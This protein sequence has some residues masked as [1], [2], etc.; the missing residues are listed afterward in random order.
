MVKASVEYGA[1][2]FD[3]AIRFFRGKLNVPTARYDDLVKE[4]HAKGFMVAGAMKAELLTDLKTAVDRVIAGGGTLETFRKDFDKIVSDNGWRY[5]GG[6]NW[7]TRVIY[8]TNLRQSYNTGRWAQVSDP[9]VVKLRPYLMYRHSG[10]SRPRPQHLAWNGLVLRQD[11][12]FWDSH[13]PQN[14]WGCNCRVDSMSDRDLARMGKAGPDTAPEIEY[15][16]YTD[17][18]GNIKQVPRGIDPGFDYNPGKAGDRSYKVLADRMETLDYDI[19]RPFV[20]EFLRGPVF[21]RFFDGDISGEFPVAVLSGA[22]K[23]ALGSK[24]QT[25]WISR[26]TLDEHKAKHTDIGLDDYRRIDEIIDGGE[27]YRRGDNR[28]SFIS[29]IGPDLFYLAGLKRTA[30]RTENYY[31]TLFKLTD[32]KARRLIREKYDRVR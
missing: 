15:R 10:S 23:E 8:H 5:K 17:R 30:D 1:L 32:S 6:R 19:A 11:D 2:P 28:L 12:P 25:V 9:E 16:E 18:D 21:E 26:G 7:R 13:A 27:A 4:M 22:D 31:L 3:E 29:P 20:S 24:A 14:G